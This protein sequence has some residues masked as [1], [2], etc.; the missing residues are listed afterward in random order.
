MSLR[1]PAEIRGGVLNVHRG[2]EPIRPLGFGLYALLSLLYPKDLLCWTKRYIVVN[3]VLTF[4]CEYITEALKGRSTMPDKD[5]VTNIRNLTPPCVGDGSTDNWNSLQ[6]A[7]NS[8]YTNLYVPAGYWKITKPLRVPIAV[9]VGRT[10][11]IFGT[12]N[13]YSVIVCSLPSS[14]SNSGALEYFSAFDSTTNTYANTSWGILLEHLTFQGKN[15]TCHGIYLKGIGYPLL[16]DIAIEGFNGAGLLID[17]CQDGEF[18]NLNVQDCGRTTG[19]PTT[20]SQTTYSAIHVTNTITPG[21][22]CNMLRFNALQCEQNKTSPYIAFKSGVGNAP[23]GIFFSQVHGEVR[24]PPPQGSP[25][26]EFFRADGGDINFDGMALSG[27]SQGFT[28][29][30]YGI[31]TFVGS[32]SLNGVS[33]QTSGKVCGAYIS[34]C[35]GVGNLYSVGTTPGFKVSNS[36]VGNVTLDYPSVEHQRFTNCSMGNVAVTHSN[37][38]VGVTIV[39]CTLASLTT[40]G[41]TSQGYYAFNVITGNLT[42]YGTKNSFVDNRVLGTTTVDTVNNYLSKNPAIASVGN[43]T[44]LAVYPAA[45]DPEYCRLEPLETRKYGKSEVKQMAELVNRLQVLLN[46]EIGR[47]K[48][49]ESRLLAAR[50]LSTSPLHLDAEL[51]QGN[52]NGEKRLS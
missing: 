26:Y 45:I 50:V 10:V 18:R 35:Q 52:S 23:I 46:A 25:G 37:V 4:P 28:F 43:T 44:R 34:S 16:T 24:I 29:T 12:S 17:K 22:G 2:L 38:G 20:V 31:S 5:D 19:T 33:L 21:D 36:A 48:D 8:G 7:L 11:R 9:N 3:E 30:G 49:L 14:Y 41:Y 39:N 13:K 42:G 27:F 40:D 1:K 51:N 32:R 6:T 47:R 15:S